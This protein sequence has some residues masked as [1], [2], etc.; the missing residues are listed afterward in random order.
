MITGDFFA[1]WGSQLS[2][3]V[4]ES[5]SRSLQRA[6]TTVTLRIEG[7]IATFCGP[8]D[9]NTVSC[10]LP[11]T[12]QTEQPAA[13][14]EFLGALPSAPQRLRVI[15]E[16][17]QFL[18]RHFSLPRAARPHLAE[19]VGYQLPKLT[20]FTTDR[21]LYACGTM[22][23][24]PSNGP[25]SVWLMTTP[26]DRIVQALTLIGQ[27]APQN[28]MRLDTPPE[29]GKPLELAWRV[30][31][32]RKSP[33]RRLRLAWIGML[34]LWIGAMGLHVFKRLEVHEQLTQTLAK[35]REEASEVTE[36]RERLLDSRS[37][38][39]WL[40]EHKRSTPS[41]IV[42]LD[43]LAQL[44]DD[45]T[46][47]QRLDF[48]GRSLRLTGISQSPSALVETLETSSSFEDVRFDAF[49]RDRR[50]QADRFNLSAK[51]EPPAREDG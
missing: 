34:A 27:T 5:L 35:V 9:A 23:D 32:P 2:D 49:S 51:V 7:E 11:T 18:V 24:S 45:Q 6:R 50:T 43:S 38:I 13:L 12:D 44:L 40:A 14:R 22:P 47:L 33:R 16:P 36:L 17:D 10:E 20:P 25:L 4:P 26:K 46:W 39:D 3:L 15:L 19:A 41:A 48:D 1:W 29:A 31:E 42:F 8:G 30:T 37:Q 28:P 21:V